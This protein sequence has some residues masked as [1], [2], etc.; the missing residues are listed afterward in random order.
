MGLARDAV[1]AIDGLSDALP[2]AVSS[3]D[4]ARWA[5]NRF[6]EA[7]RIVDDAERR[8]RRAVWGLLCDE[9]PLAAAT[10]ADAI[11]APLP[12]VARVLAVD[13]DD[14]DT[15][16]VA[17]VV[18]RTAG[19][20]AWIVRDADDETPVVVLLAVGTHAPDDDS[21]A[22]H[23]AHELTTRHPQCRVG[24]SPV[25]E[26]GRVGTAYAQARHALAAAR[27]AVGGYARFHAWLDP[28]L[29][30]SHQA[31][32]WARGALAPLTHHQPRRRGDPDAA[33]LVDTLTTWLAD[34]RSAGTRLGIHRNTLSGRLKLIQDV[35]GRNLYRVGD[36]AELSLALRVASVSDLSA[37]W[38]RADSA[39]LPEL[40]EV[41]G[42]PGL[43]EFT[44]PRAP[45]AERVLPESGVAEGGPATSAT[46]GLRFS[47]NRLAEHGPFSGGAG[48]GG[49]PSDAHPSPDRRE[50]A[51]ANPR[52]GDAGYA[53]DPFPPGR[54]DR[55][56]LPLDL[57]VLENWAYAGLRTLT[58]GP[59]G[60]DA[61]TLRIWLAHDAR[62]SATA[63]A[64]GL[65]VP[66]AR[67]RLTRIGGVL[68][69]DLLHGPTA[70]A[71]LWLALRVVDR[72]GSPH[73]LA[74]DRRRAS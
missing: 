50:H 65:T 19:R 24:S 49:S 67:K 73:N 68:G 15:D 47:A 25:V 56:P 27:V 31:E 8:Q 35:L 20:S 53:R 12:D 21:A 29:L 13:C 23:L 4:L 62:L 40:S 51:S 54:F 36:R 30:I 58:G 44:E 22:R 14:A 38:G 74:E 10:M 57:P 9:Q 71:D 72:P 61:R 42:M 7:V 41:S 70:E 48:T 28:E 45:E 60:A 32:A 11:G 37:R 16:A 46:T 26:P 2:D 1:A 5:A 39:E 69:L 18:R 6:A 3:V 55:P 64:L 17:A 43:P 33:E 66:G 59:G 52:N 63:E 34:R